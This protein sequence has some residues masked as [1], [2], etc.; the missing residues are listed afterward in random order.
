MAQHISWNAIPS[1]Q[2]YKAEKLVELRDLQ[3]KILNLR[4]ELE[5]SKSPSR[6]NV[7]SL[8]S[9]TTMNSIQTVGVQ[10]VAA[11]ERMTKQ[12]IEAK[13][14]WLIEQ[15][16]SVLEQAKINQSQDKRSNEHHPIIKEPSQ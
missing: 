1:F 2:K 11:L 16:E 13:S 9:E 8:I 4:H 5:S 10:T 7:R 3:Q 14:R 15:R 12:K 6:N